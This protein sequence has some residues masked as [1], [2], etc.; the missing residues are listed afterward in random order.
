MSVSTQKDDQ[1][2]QA[3]YAAIGVSPHAVRDDPSIARIEVHANRVLGVHLVPGLLVDA[4]ETKEGI[5]ATIR[6]TQGT[7]IER[8]VQVCFGMI[9]E[10]GLQRIGLTI[11]VEENAR[12]AILAHCVFPFAREVRHEMD[13]TIRIAPGARY[14]YLERHVHGPAG[15]VTV[16]PRTRVQVCERGQYRTDFEL[17]R[18]RVGAIEIDLEATCEA[19]ALMEV[20]ARVHATGDDRVQIREVGHLAGE[21][22]TG[23]LVSH[24]AVRDQ[25]RAEVLSTLTATAAYARGHVDCKEIV[26]GEAEARATPVVEVL[27][28]KAHVTHEA[29]IGS[30]DSRQL[31]TLMSRGLTEEEATDLIIQGLLSRS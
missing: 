21:H 9:P 11:E 7:Q 22:A 17:L 16:I 24:I 5:E 12:A 4:T 27:H 29:A 13:A 14:A 6:V 3:L 10:T 1:L 26:Q 28:P 18:G 25:S 31:E 2:V 20:R 15:G 23:A 30:V 19:H 8:P